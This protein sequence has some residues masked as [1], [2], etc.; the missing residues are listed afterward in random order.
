MPVHVEGLNSFILYYTFKQKQVSSTVSR[1]E[2]RLSKLV[3]GG[4]KMN[5]G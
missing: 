2:R 4:T 3:E 1:Y 5:V